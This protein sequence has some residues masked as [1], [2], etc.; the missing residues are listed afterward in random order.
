MTGGAPGCPA[1]LYPKLEMPL[2]SA[3]PKEFKVALSVDQ[4]W[5]T[6]APEVRSNTLA[7]IKRLEDSGVRVEEI[8]LNLET[9][10]AQMRESIEKAL[11]STAIGADL[12]D[13][14]SKAGQ[15][16]TY[17]QRFVKLACEMGPTDARDAAKEALRLYE[18]ID[19][20]VFDKGY[21]ALLTPT[22]A[23][24][25][26]A[27]DYDPTKDR[28]N[29]KGKNVDPYSGWFLTSVFSLLNWMPV[30]N[31]PTGLSTNNV[32]TGMQIACRPYD[33][34]TAAMI[35]LRYAETAIPMPFERLAV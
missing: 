16:T 27:A 17:S 34:V 15:L 10:D 23:T 9:S 2:A 29:I 5:A 28:I 35:A 32:P 13:L 12:I 7:A 26:I 18:I 4:G 1:V 30:V 25:Q 20:C 31:V 8:E 24:T 19:R 14:K 33:D 3:Q 11:F 21:E 22:V 6:I